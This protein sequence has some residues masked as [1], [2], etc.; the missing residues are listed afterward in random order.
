MREDAELSISEITP[1]ESTDISEGWNL[2]GFASSGSRD[3][4]DAISSI[5]ENV[6]SVWAYISGKWQVYDPQ[7]PEFSDLTTMAPG[8]GYWIKARTACSWIY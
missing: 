4:A 3:T 2:V 8:N 5:A 7:N 6:T 1:V